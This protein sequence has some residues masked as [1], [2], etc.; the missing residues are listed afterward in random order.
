[1]IADGDRLEGVYALRAMPTAFPDRFISLRF[2]ETSGRDR[3]VGIIRALADWPPAAQEAVRVSLRRHYFLRQ[4]EEI[5]QM[6]TRENML[7]LLVATDS[8]PATICLDKPGEG[9]QPFGPNGLLLIDAAGNCFVIAD[10]DALSKRQ[11]RLLT[12]YFGD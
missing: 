10:R 4:V 8:G 3:E 11:Q 2:R 7:T 12:L 1:M 9:S 5:R 6:C